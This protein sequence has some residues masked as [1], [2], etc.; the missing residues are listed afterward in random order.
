MDIVTK[1]ERSKMM[2]G[3]KSKNTKPEIIIRK[4][5]LDQDLSIA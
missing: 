1:K 3:I 2:A 4:I 5:L